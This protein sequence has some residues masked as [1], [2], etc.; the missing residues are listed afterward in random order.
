MI[1]MK[2]FSTIKSLQ[3]HLKSVRAQ[4]RSIGLV[5]T[6]GSLH[7]GH[8][9]LIAQ[10]RKENDVTVCSIFVN[11]KQ[12]NNKKDLQKYPRNLANDL[13]FLKSW[14]CDTVFAPSEKEIYPNSEAELTI[15]FGTVDKILEGK[16]RPGHFSGVGIIVSK[17]FNIVTPDRA[18]FGLKD[19]QQCFIIRHLVDELSFGVK[20]RFLKTVREEN[21]LAVSSRNKRLSKKEFDVASDIFRILNLAKKEIMVTG[22]IKGGISNS[23][24]ILKGMKPIELEYMEPVNM[25]DFSIVTSEIQ[26]DSRVA[27]CVAAYV[28]EVRLIDNV[29]FKLTHE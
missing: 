8:H 23:K 7:K 24:K 11:R 4:K 10:S 5:P 19:I 17:L 18:Y 26:K 29:I 3:N 2:V 16:F 27:I 20:L 13:Q 12:F 21:G 25:K 1:Y 6:M 9:A 15:N 14:G 22:D 28:G